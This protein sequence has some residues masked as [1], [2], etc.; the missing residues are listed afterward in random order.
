M[1]KELQPLIEEARKYKTLD[2]FREA[3]RKARSQR[4]PS[5]LKTIISKA[6][7]YAKKILKEKGK[8]LYL[9]DI[10]QATK[11]R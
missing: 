7:K 3:V 4:K 6:E 10:Y 1:E 8:V 11:I 5:K 9:Q 2:E